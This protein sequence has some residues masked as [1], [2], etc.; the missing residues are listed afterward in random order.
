MVLFLNIAIEEI[1]GDMYDID[2]YDGLETVVTPDNIGWTIIK[3]GI[4]SDR[5]FE[6]DC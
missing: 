3:C 5:Y 1:D 4:N 2:E 6:N